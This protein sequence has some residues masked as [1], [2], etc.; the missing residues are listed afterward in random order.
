ME[1]FFMKQFTVIWSVFIMMLAINFLTAQTVNVTFRANS[2]TVPDTMTANSVFQIRGDT[3][4]LTWGDDTGGEL[5]NVGGD[6]W[7]V[8]LAMP[9][10]STIQYKFFANAVG[11][12]QGSGWESNVSGD[13][14]GN[15]IL[16]TG[17]TD[18]TLALQFFN[19]IGGSD[20]YATPYV[21]TDFMDVWF[22]VNV[23]AL[24][25]QNNFA[26]A[27]Q[28]IMVKG[29]TWP[30][31]WGDLTWNADSTT[32]GILKGE[33][34]SDNGGQF[35]YFGGDSLMWSGRIRIPQ[36]SVNVGQTVGYKFVIAERANP[37]QITWESTPD[38]PFIVPQGKQDT[39]VMWSYFN[40]VP[41]VATTGQDTIIVKFRIDLTEAL[42]NDGV[43]PGDTVYAQW[44]FGGTAD[45]SQDTLVYDPLSP[46]N[47]Y[48]VEDTVTSVG[49]GEAL[50][51]QYYLYKNGQQVREN[52]FNYDYTG[53]QANLAE[54]REITIPSSG[55]QH[56]HLTIRDT[57]A[58]K[59]DSRR[60]PRF[61]NRRVLA[62]EVSVI[63][64]C[65]VRPAYWQVHLNGDTLFHTQSTN[66]DDWIKPGQEDSII[67][68]GPYINGPGN[69]TAGW[70]DP[71]SP[72]N[73][74]PYR[75][76]DDGPGGGHG[77][78]VAGDSIYSFTVKFS[79]DSTPPDVVGQEFKFGIH[80]WDNE[81]GGRGGF[82]N[83]HIENIDDSQSIF[84]LRIDFGSINP[85]YYSR[86]DF[87]N[88]VVGIENPDEVTVITTPMLN[89]NYPNP[90]NPVTT[91]SFVLPRAMKVELVIYDVLGR[92]VRT[93]M[94]GTYKAGAQKVLW[95]GNNDRG[96]PVSSGIYFYRLK[97]E[98]YDKTMRMLLVK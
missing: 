29:G 79:P 63:Y 97:T 71:W 66:P 96:I 70:Q 38:R 12:A 6:Y 58:S 65:D 19:K 5:T 55:T 93:L 84:Y 54:R 25:Q 15:R 98:N 41:P 51:Y 91:I 86:W 24:I 16:Q 50:F 22:R 67:T 80:G 89:H 30:G 74:E 8:T 60:M 78:E 92:K 26:P 4:P 46:G 37:T 36:D 10:N 18:T 17:I 2:A 43:N 88:H 27:S 44:G 64:T 20:P 9:S 52:Y 49:F 69:G 72:S 13:P 62:Q 57:V 73:L 59:V 31:A 39:T 82:G 23:Q 14:S 85:R 47:M 40:N 28:M 32:I 21:P 1:V 75:M 33:I 11:N 45:Q 61:P 53:S 81:N 95:S 77:D 76:F 56:M 48:Q 34:D 35:S 87:D 90:F 42:N 94:N 3:S 68:W 83:N 7:E